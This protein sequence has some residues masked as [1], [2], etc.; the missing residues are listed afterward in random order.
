MNNRLLKR[1]RI[2]IAIVVGVLS[3]LAFVFKFYPL[4]IFDMQFTAALQNSLVTG[5]G[6]SVFLFVLLIVLTLIF[7]RIYCSTLCPLG[8]FQEL[9]MFLFKPVYRYRLYQRS[10]RS[11]VTYVCAALLFGSLLGGTAFLMRMVDPYSLAGNALSGAFYGV[12]FIFCLT[13]LVFFKKRFF[14]TNICPVGAVLGFLSRFSLFK[15]HIDPTKCKACMTCARQCPAA[16]INPKNGKLNNELCLKCFQCLPVCP[17]GA[18]YYGTKRENPQPFSLKRR[19]LLVSGGV[20]LAFFAA[21]KGG[22]D[23][24]KKAVVNFKNAVIPAGAGNITDFA[25]KCLNCNLCVQHCP[26][27]IIKKATM[28]TPFVHLDYSD[29]YCAYDCHRCSEVCPSG[30]IKH[31]TLAEKQKTKIATAVVDESICV[32]CG[33]CAR[34]CPRQI[35]IK[36]EGAFPIIRFDQCIGCGACA[37]SCPVKAISMDAA[38]KQTLLS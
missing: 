14:C 19:Q 24:M 38:E 26:R 25:N 31:I 22:L 6:I 29:T 28:E 37:S 20:A 36:T 34:K 27:Q 1:L 18:I 32:K 33:L 10:H 5:V 35:I 12:M 4:K 7:G 2:G 9:L 11:T 3:L 16:C 23:L 17:Q 21:F 30:A 15:I 13:L 8:I